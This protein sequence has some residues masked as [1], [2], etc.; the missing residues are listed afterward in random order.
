MCQF[1]F[2]GVILEPVNCLY[3]SQYAS[4]CS[5]GILGL[6]VALTTHPSSPSG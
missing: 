2:R 4:G 5:L 1:V 3:G 6:S